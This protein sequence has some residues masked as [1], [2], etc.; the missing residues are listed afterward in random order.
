MYAIIFYSLSR[1]RINDIRV[2]SYM[3]AID[4]AMSNY[5]RRIQMIFVILAKQEV[6][7]YSAVKKKC[8]IDY[9]GELQ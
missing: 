3:A 4:Q 6:D 5:G 8:T 2:P 7:V 1:L 9:G